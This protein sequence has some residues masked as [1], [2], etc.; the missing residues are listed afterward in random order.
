[1]RSRGSPA[2]VDSTYLSR[3]G[4]HRIRELGNRMLERTDRPS[5]GQRPIASTLILD[6]LLKHQKLVL[7]PRSFI[8]VPPIRVLIRP[9]TRGL[10]GWNSTRITIFDSC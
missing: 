4:G 10:Q 2:A 9:H 5:R 7:R 8:R 3:Y 1:M 6:G